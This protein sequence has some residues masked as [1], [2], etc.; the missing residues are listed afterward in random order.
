MDPVAFLPEPHE[1]GRDFGQQATAFGFNKDASGAN[2]LEAVNAAGYL[3]RFAL[4]NEDRPHALL[5]CQAD[6]RRFARVQQGFQQHVPF[7]GERDDTEPDSSPEARQPQAFET[8][9]FDF[10]LDGLGDE[11][12]GKKLLEHIQPVEEAQRNQRT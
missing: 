5:P 12:L 8:T 3:S 4:V 1:R 7:T 9:F 2:D 11:D 10:A 6:D